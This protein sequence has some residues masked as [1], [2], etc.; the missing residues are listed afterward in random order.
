[1]S[2]N[3]TNNKDTINEIY[4]LGAPGSGSDCSPSEGSMGDDNT[5]TSSVGNIDID[6][7]DLGMDEQ[8]LG[9]ALVRH[10]PDGRGETQLVV[11]NPKR[12]ELFEE[13][14]RVA[15]MRITENT[16]KQY[17]SA[18][19]GYVLWLFRNDRS[20]L[21]T[22][23]LELF[24]ASYEESEDLDLI[25]VIKKVVT[26][27]ELN[28][29]DLSKFSSHIFFTYLLSLRNNEDN[30]YSYSCYDGK[31]SALMHMV[32]S[33]KSGSIPESEHLLLKELMV[34]LRKSIANEKKKKG[35]KTSEGKEAMTFACYKLTCELL[36]A[37]GTS[38]SIFALCWL[39]MQWNLMSRSE[40]TEAISFSHMRWDNDTLKVFF[41][42]HKSDQ[43]G[44]N[45]DEA[46]H[47]YS[48]PLTP[49][50]CPLRALACYCM[51][52]PKVLIDNHFLFPGS[53][54]KTRFNRI[55]HAVLDRNT[56]IYEASGIDVSE[57]GSHSI[58]KGAATYCCTGCHP[59]PPIISVCLRAGWTL[60]SVKERYLRYDN[61][62]DEVVGRTL[63]GISPSTSEFA[64]S[65]VYFNENTDTK[66]IDNMCNYVFPQ[67]NTKLLG[68]I[69]TLL[70]TFI[71]HE[72]WTTS[73]TPAESPLM[74]S[75]YFAFVD[76]TEE[77]ESY[78]EWSLPWHKK[79]C[80]PILTGIPMHC[81]LLNKMDLMLKMQ[82]T[83]PGLCV[84]KLIEELDIRG[85]SGG[86]SSVP[87]ALIKKV[88]TLSDQLESVLTNERNR[89]KENENVVRDDI[90]EQACFNKNTFGTRRSHSPIL[91]YPERGIWSHFWDNRLRQVPE[92][93]TFPKNKTLLSLWLSWHIPDIGRK[94]C[95]WRFLQYYDMEKIKRGVSKHREMGVV[96]SRMIDQL[97]SSDVHRM[98]YINGQ[99][100]MTVLTNLFDFASSMF[101]N[102]DIRKA[103]FG[104]LSWETFVKE[105]RKMRLRNYT[106]EKH[107]RKLPENPSAFMATNI[108]PSASQPDSS[109][110]PTSPTDIETETTTASVSTAAA[111][112]PLPTTVTPTPISPPSPPTARATQRKRKPT[113][114][115]STTKVRKPRKATKKST[116]TTPFENA[117][118]G[119]IT[120]VVLKRN[121]ANQFIPAPCAFCDS[122]HP[123][124]T[125]H[126]CTV[127]QKGG[128]IDGDVE[129]CGRPY[130]GPCGSS[131]GCEGAPYRCKNHVG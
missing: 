124:P 86:G 111:S 114:K 23:F 39:V 66:Y 59:G 90:I 98:N 21:K 64:I 82:Q 119:K 123:L 130:C 29:L 127:L 99:N 40:A 19:A 15:R 74:H 113:S 28:P 79:K 61:A 109:L 104:Q 60:G 38:E 72:K 33:D 78:V 42:R 47:V 41:P 48:N 57:L 26:E 13:M 7:G 53:D 62:G 51:I 50:V 84:D 3:K 43:V 16:R 94:V 118:D 35:L 112:T 12:K 131:W 37:E 106:P 46:R 95:P 125:S 73:S 32:R 54:Q 100:D 49:A 121:A 97:Y 45:K 71:F 85:I 115:T 87:S 89:Q 108:P 4:D 65:P 107:A 96:I 10:G 52:F 92:D 58:R 30:F 34:S 44:L 88:E 2:N 9:A 31:R 80:C 101:K 120:Q 55:F 11:H 20:Q 69:K 70:A 105:A 128:M 77:R 75:L 76:P 122:M 116:S 17:N 63:T 68:L 67:A 8:D 18:N 129:I 91:I 1:M 93:F 36:I 22:D 25:S 110:T 81:V 117:F 83:L 102:T 24:Q 56:A 126:R 5:V 14:K 6:A 27:E 103:R